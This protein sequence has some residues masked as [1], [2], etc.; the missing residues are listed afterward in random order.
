MAHDAFAAHAEAE[1]HIDPNDLTNPWQAALASAAS[2]SVGGIVPILAVALPARC[3]AASVTVI[4]RL[5]ALIITG[6]LSAQVG[7]A[8]KTKAVLRVV[9]GGII[10]M[11]VTFGVGK[12]FGGIGI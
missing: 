6:M 8:N 10:A 12:L 9:A 1:L 7:G 4:A 2:F 3:R 5:I 11:A